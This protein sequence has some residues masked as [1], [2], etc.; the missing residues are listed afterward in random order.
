[1]ADAAF[2]ATKRDTS[3][4]FE[5]TVATDLATAK[6]AVRSGLRRTMTSG[7]AVSARGSFLLYYLRAT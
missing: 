1:M 3:F 5:D 2:K 7:C 6:S 4:Y